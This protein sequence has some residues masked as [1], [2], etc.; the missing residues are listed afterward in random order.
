MSAFSDIVMRGHPSN[1]P[2]NNWQPY[3][4]DETADFMAYFG[5][6]HKALFDYKGKLM[7]EAVM[8]GT[9]ITRPL[10]YEF[11]EDEK[12]W[13]VKDQFMLGSDIL[14]APIFEVGS[15]TRDVYLPPG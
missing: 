11:P 9:L 1:K 13:L 15:S 2:V 4:D 5:K 10:F 8:K 3:S 7:D 14:V 6:I 12:S